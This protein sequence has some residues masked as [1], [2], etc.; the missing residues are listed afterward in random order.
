MKYVKNF[1]SSFKS[2][3]I[4]ANIEFAE[5]FTDARKLMNS[6]DYSGKFFIRVYV[7]L[8]SLF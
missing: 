4:T 7:G 5:D 3:S 1:H 8:H 6:F 2:F